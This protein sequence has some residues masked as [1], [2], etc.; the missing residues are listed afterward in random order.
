MDL[1]LRSILARILSKCFILIREFNYSCASIRGGDL[2]GV[3]LAVFGKC[4]T[5]NYSSPND[6]LKLAGKTNDGIS[7]GSIR[8]QSESFSVRVTLKNV[9]INLC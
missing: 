2:V 5:D 7:S 9:N 8:D 6:V 4:H 3:G 1:Q